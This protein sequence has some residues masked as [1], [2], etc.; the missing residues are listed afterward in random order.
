MCQD[1][2]VR[3]ETFLVNSLVKARISSSDA[4]YNMAA[5]NTNL[6]RCM[7]SLRQLTVHSPHDHVVSI[8]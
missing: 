8:R 1:I 4:I 6:V 2:Y 3:T 7:Q 5:G